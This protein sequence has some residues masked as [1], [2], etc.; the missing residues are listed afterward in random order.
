M[1]DERIEK[2]GTVIGEA[3]GEVIYEVICGIMDD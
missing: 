2:I 3:L 1:T